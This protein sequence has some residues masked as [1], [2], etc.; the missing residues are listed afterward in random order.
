MALTVSVVIAGGASAKLS[1]MTKQPAT[2]D[3]LIISLQAEAG[4]TVALCAAQELPAGDA[5][6]DWIMLLPAGEEVRT[7][8]NRGPYPVKDRKAIIARSLQFE[9]G[10]VLDENHATDVAAPRGE[11]APARGWITALE[12]RPDGIY[13]RVDWTPV[14]RRLMAQKAYRFISPVV[15]HDSKTNEALAIARASL[16]NK[17]NLRGMASLHSEQ[18]MNLL[19]KL[20]AKLG[21]ADTTSEDTLI[22]AVEALH[23][24]STAAEASLQ[25][26]LDPIAE[27][28]GLKKGATVEAVLGALGT[29]KVG[30]GTA[31]QVVAL[32]Q[33]LA[34]TTT[35]LNGLLETGKR[36]K[37]VAA[38]DAAIAAKTVGVSVLRDH[39]ITRHM[40][41][42]AAVEKELAALPKLGASHTTIVPPGAK[43]GDLDA[44]QRQ[45]IALMGIDPEAYKKT[46]AAE[47][48]AAEA[49]L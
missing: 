32:Q 39:Y 15:L 24:E 10:M 18:D 44:T 31:A 16:V 2:P 36:D 12:D 45:A 47:A 30:G 35:T 49:A 37:A 25:A 27:A 21:L 38:I 33:E 23:A 6:P 11:P 14:G 26:Q 42:P 4:E 41:N 1:P 46:L 3:V 48:A 22:A 13:G 19:Q 28:A 7:H 20:L 5:V 9:R 8:D 29:L 43:P 40:E 17:P 34:T